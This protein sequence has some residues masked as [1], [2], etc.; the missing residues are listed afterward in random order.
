MALSQVS[1]L[2]TT[3]NRL[4]VCSLAIF[5]LY[6]EHVTQASGLCSGSLPASLTL[7]MKRCRGLFHNA[8]G[9]SCRGESKHFSGRLKLIS[10]VL[11]SLPGS[12][13]DARKV[14]LLG[15]IKSLA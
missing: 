13:F 2:A 14:A 8:V 1:T 9:E 4:S 11:P 12:V 15:S 3:D 10:P 6:Q 5:L 7:L